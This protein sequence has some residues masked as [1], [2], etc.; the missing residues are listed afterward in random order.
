MATNYILHSMVF[1]FKTTE[2][3]QQ[4]LYSSFHGFL[5]QIEERGLVVVGE[6][7][8]TAV[9]LPDS[10]LEVTVRGIIRGKKPNA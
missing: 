6:P 10:I 1:R 7:K 5:K 2:D 9:V 8:A 4:C 3:T